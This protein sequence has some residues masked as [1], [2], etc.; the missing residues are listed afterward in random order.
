MLES[1]APVLVPLASRDTPDVT[2]TVW[3]VVQTT[4]HHSGQPL[5]T[6]LRTIRNVLRI[7]GPNVHPRGL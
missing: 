7:S 1:F 2:C 6:D 3:W 4:L 5:S